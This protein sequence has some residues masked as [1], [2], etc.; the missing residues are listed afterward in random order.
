MSNICLAIL[1]YRL[2]EMVLVR[3]LCQ[4]FLWMPFFAAFFGGIPFH[5]LLAICA[6]MFGIDMSRGATAKVKGRSTFMTEW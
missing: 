2:S 6:H 4:N 5:L 3:S 1:R